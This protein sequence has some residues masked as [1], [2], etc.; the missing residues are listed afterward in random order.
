MTVTGKHDAW[1][2][3]KF[4]GSSVADVACMRQVAS[5]VE[6]EPAGRL[7]LVLSASRGVTDALLDL[8]ALAERQEDTDAQL[9]TLRQRHADMA[10]ALWERDEAAIA[11]RFPLQ[12]LGEPEDIANAVL[13]LCSDAASWITGHVLVIDGGQL[14][15]S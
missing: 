15:S 8:V 2:V 6:G 11:K 9:A 1:R 4:G 10:R 5:I 3:F 13:F 12:R 14:V 7:A